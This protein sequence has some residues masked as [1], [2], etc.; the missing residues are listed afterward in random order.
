MGHQFC[1]L[2]GYQLLP[3][4]KVIH[5][6]HQAHIWD[7]SGV[8]IDSAGIGEGRNLMLILLF[9]DRGVVHYP[10]FDHIPI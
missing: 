10:Y 8:I 7:F 2:L 5:N 6:P 3:K 4:S 9:F 1:H